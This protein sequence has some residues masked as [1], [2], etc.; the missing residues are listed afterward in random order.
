MTFH[1][2]NGNGP[3]VCRSGRQVKHNRMFAKS[4]LPQQRAPY[5]TTLHLYLAPM[6]T[7]YPLLYPNI[8]HIAKYMDSVE[9]PRRV[10][11]KKRAPS[12]ERPPSSVSHSPPPLPVLD[13][14]EVSIGSSCLPCSH[15]CPFDVCFVFL[16]YSSLID[17]GN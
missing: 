1:R 4:Q 10:V 3:V 13:W 9:S 11:T 2:A 6:L 17:Q 16:L 12:S 15:F 7:H 5:A 14:A 8:N